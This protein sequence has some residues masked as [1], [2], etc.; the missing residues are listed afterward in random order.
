MVLTPSST[1]NFIELKLIY[2]I[3][4][5][6]LNVLYLAWPFDKKLLTLPLMTIMH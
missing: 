5:F 4:A 3:I 1:Y 6:Y 2:L